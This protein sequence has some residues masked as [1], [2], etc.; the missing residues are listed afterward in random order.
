MMPPLILQIGGNLARDL[1]AIER[2]GAVLG[3]RAQRLGVV[4][5][6]EAIAGARHLAAGQVD[7]RRLG[8]LLEKVA[9]VGD[10]SS[11]APRRG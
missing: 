2:L 6:D 4:L 1:A 3:D 9:A 8:I 10:A 11:A 5:V 7:A